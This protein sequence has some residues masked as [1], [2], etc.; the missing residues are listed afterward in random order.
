[1]VSLPPSA[2]VMGDYWVLDTDYDNYTLIYSCE[3][4]LGVAHIEF[5]WILARNMT[6]DQSLTDRLMAELK[7]YGV[8]VTKFHKSDQEGCPA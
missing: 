7:G 2:S 8:D 5:A 1:M 4:I 6:V 3:S